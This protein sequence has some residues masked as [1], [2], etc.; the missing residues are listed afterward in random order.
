MRACLRTF[1]GQEYSVGEEKPSIE[2]FRCGIC[3]IGYNPQMSVEE[4]ELMA[5]QLSMSADEFINRYIDITRVGYL[6]RQTE[7]GCVFLTWEEGTAES[8]CSIY[9]IR[10]TACRNWVPSLSRRGCREGLVKLQ[11][12]D[13]MLLVGEIYETQEQIERFCALLRQAGE[14]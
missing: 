10:P 9:S 2:C 7:N 4:V 12:V 14:G 11:K 1:N 5:G 3:C 13:R 6:L 8:S